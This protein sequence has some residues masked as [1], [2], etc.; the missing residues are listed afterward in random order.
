[1][2]GKRCIYVFVRWQEGITFR[3]KCKCADGAKTGLKERVKRLFQPDKD[4]IKRMAFMDTVMIISVTQKQAFLTIIGE[5]S[6]TEDT[7]GIT[8]GKLLG[9]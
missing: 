9:T 3:L 2:R 5:V 1:M 7:Y 6:A 4:G 8:T